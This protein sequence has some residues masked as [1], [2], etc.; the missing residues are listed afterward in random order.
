MRRV[1]F[2]IDQ[3]CYFASVEMISHPEY[4]DVPMA[5]AGDEKKRHGIILA[6]NQLASG[7]G[8]KTAEPIW[9]AQSKCPNLVLAQ[10]HY[11]EYK[12]YS[13]RLREM[14]EEYS[15]KVESFGL[16]ECWVD[17]TDACQGRD[18]KELADEIRARVRDEFGL[19]CSVGV[20]FNKIFA[21]LG[22]DYKKPDATTVITEEN[23]RS[24]VWPLPVS[25]L[26]F[27]GKKTANY[28]KQVNINTIGELANS[29]PTF[30]A[31]Y[32]GKSGPEL[33]NHAN[34]ID[35]DEVKTTDYVRAVKSVG[36]STTTPNDLT[37]TSQVQGVL[38]KIASKVSYRLRSHN[39]VAECIQIH[40]RDNELN[41]YE[42]QKVLSEATDSD[43]LIYDAACKLFEESY[44]WERNIRSVGI[45]CTKLQDAGGGVQMSIFDTLENKK[46]DDKLTGVIDKINERY[47]QGSIRSA[48]ELFG[49]DNDEV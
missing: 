46:K 5:V 29:D 14:Y 25:D 13:M 40:I 38:M 10:P 44:S 4:R 16:D 20:S 17:M 7:Y 35:N 18:P 22:S 1:I 34:G 33:W 27:V 31:E 43:V 48:R 41:I 37:S 2:H 42:H 3:N 24:I 9:Q 15:D 21:K 11:D 47:G 26:L 36:N 39:M 30:I 23:F 19:T 32:L 45:R 28:L 6:K 49:E 12:F 8:V